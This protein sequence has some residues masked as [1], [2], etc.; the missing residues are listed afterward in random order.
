MMIREKGGLTLSKLRGRDMTV[1]NLNVYILLVLA[2]TKTPANTEFRRCIFL[3]L[4]NTSNKP[5]S[6]NRKQCSDI[7]TSLC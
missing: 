3:N 6:K 1:T 5:V 2:P 7:R 4:I